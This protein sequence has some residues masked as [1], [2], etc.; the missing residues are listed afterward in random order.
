MQDFYI[1]IAATSIFTVI[2]T[3]V[4][5]HYVNKWVQK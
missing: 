4:G 5:Q 1:V 3:L 2:L